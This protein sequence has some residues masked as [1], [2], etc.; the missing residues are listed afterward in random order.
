MDKE[1]LKAEEEKLQ[2]QIDNPTNKSD[3][4][5]QLLKKRLAAI[6]NKRDDIAK[7][8]KNEAA[9]ASSEKQ[10]SPTEPVIAQPTKE[11]L[12][13]QFL[14]SESEWK[15]MSEEAKKAFIKSGS[16]RTKEF[17]KINQILRICSS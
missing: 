12:V 9:G 4:T 17:G 1:A 6:K 10:A 16:T 13:E 14:K 8:E 5:V 15:G 11:D 7:K 2:S 3:K